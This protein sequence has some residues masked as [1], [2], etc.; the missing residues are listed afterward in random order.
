MSGKNRR[1]VADEPVELERWPVEVQDFK[2]FTDRF[3][4]YIEY[5]SNE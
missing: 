2:E 3:K 1:L 5:T 4:E